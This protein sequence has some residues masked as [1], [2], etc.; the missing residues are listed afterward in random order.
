MHVAGLGS[1]GQSIGNAFRLSRHCLGGGAFV[2]R[3]GRDGIGGRFRLMPR[4]ARAG[5]DGCTHGLV[6]SFDAGG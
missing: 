6:P 1:A 3:V 4:A 2:G 5:I